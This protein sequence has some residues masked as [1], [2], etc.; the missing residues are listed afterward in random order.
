[1]ATDINLAV[2]CPECC[3][4]PTPITEFSSRAADAGIGCYYPFLDYTT[5][6]RRWRKAIVSGAVAADSLNYYGWD[7]IY[8]K[9]SQ[10]ATGTMYIRQ[11]FTACSSETSYSASPYF[12]TSSNGDS[13]LA[14]EPLQR[15]LTGETLPLN[16]GNQDLVR[17][18]CGGD[19]SCFDMVC[20]TSHAVHISAASADSYTLRMRD[21]S[22]DPYSYITVTLDTELTFSEV[23][24][25]AI[26]ALPAWG[27]TWTTTATSGFTIQ[28]DGIIVL[29]YFIQQVRYRFRFK[30]PTM[31]SG[32]IYRVKWVERFVEA[33][34][35][36]IDSVE[37]VNRGCCRPAVSSSGGG[38]SGLLL[39]AV[40]NS[41]GGVASI[42]ILNPGSGY[43]S[44]P[45]ITVASSIGGTTST[46]WVATVSGG[47]V[48]SI[49]GGA[50]GNYLPT[51]IVSGGGSGAV[52]ALTMDSSGGI[53]SATVTT[54]GSGYLVT[55]TLLV[56]YKTTNSL[57]PVLFLHF[58]AESNF[59]DVWDGTTPSG[60]DPD[61]NMTWPL[62]P[63]AA[64]Q[65]YE[66][67]SYGAYGS[68][69][70]ANVETSC[71]EV[72]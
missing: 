49:S 68:V 22:G 32:E 69:R 40:M 63:S 33:G 19:V 55:S 71:T 45:T 13:L 9:S 36:P 46:G 66:M 38:G 57:D 34:G 37:I 23:E 64:P 16:L 61:D 18:Y 31:G 60:Y 30:I 25:E 29:Y 21:N 35:V 42:T 28:E 27:S 52:I 41:S 48:T 54:P 59:C 53:A 2:D 67:S 15:D 11:Q 14:D 65:Y 8:N 58:G 51:A 4:C 50:V 10:S 70:V 44:A 20:D 7:Y 6:D 56:A 72:C 1:M 12:S 5:D 39:V 24:T 47:V 3:A 26:A 43:T 17:V 62:L